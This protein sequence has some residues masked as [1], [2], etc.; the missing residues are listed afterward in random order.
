[1][2]CL[3]NLKEL[4]RQLKDKLGISTLTEKKDRVTSKQPQSAQLARAGRIGLQGVH[5]VTY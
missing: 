1:M 2:Q 5:A 4:D 3:K